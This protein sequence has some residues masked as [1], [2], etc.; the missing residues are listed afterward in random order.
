[1]LLINLINSSVA[2]LFVID[3]HLSVLR[4][5]KFEST[6]DFSLAY[7]FKLDIYNKASPHIMHFAF[8][9]PHHRDSFKLERDVRNS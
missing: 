8:Y 7:I 9:S 6:S 4:V 3:C 2:I 5:G 1:M